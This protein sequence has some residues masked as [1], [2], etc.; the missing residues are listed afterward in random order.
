MENGLLDK[1]VKLAEAGMT[2]ADINKIIDAEIA[3]K[4]D[5]EPKPDD[6]KE[7]EGKEDKK[8]PDDKKEPEG[9]EDKKDP[10]ERDEKIAELEK[11]LK[12]AQDAARRSGGGESRE[13]QDK[14]AYTSLLSKIKNF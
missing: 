8:D 4:K 6:K 7:P 5:P 14:K 13:E 9:K 11:Q 3:G 1:A 12:A 2:A 10:D